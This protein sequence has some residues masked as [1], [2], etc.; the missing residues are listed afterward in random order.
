MSLKNFI[1]KNINLVCDLSK[2]KIIY[3][4]ASLHKH[5]SI[6]R[7]ELNERMGKRYSIVDK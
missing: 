2:L 4:I 7:E 3:T 1:I 5:Q 6:S